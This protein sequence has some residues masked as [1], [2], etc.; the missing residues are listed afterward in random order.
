MY[1]WFDY[2]MNDNYNKILKIFQFLISTIKQ[3]FLNILDS[4][5]IFFFENN[6]K[7]T[8]YWL[9]SFFFLKI[10]INIATYE[11]ITVYMLDVFCDPLELF[12][13]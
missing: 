13:P 11:I 1:F 5:I 7:M 8:Y 10:L 6:F 3:F 9:I 2:S 4:V 12:L